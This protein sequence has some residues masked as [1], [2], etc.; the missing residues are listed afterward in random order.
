MVGV[1]PRLFFGGCFFFTPKPS[2]G[3]FGFFS[4][5]LG[6]GII[7]DPHFFFPKAQAGFINWGEFFFNCWNHKTPFFPKIQKKKF[8]KF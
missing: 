1:G 8:L 6:G 5:K 2:K 7:W 3:G 4:G